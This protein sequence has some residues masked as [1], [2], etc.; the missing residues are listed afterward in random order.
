MICLSNNRVSH[1]MQVDDVLNYL[2]DIYPNTYA[3]LEEVFPEIPSRV[4]DGAAFDVELMGVDQ[5]WSSWVADRI[6]QDT[7]VFW[8]EGEPIML[9]DGDDPADW[10]E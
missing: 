4:L 6:E 5:E 10:T 8:W 2:R 9:E 7:D 1:D 3:A